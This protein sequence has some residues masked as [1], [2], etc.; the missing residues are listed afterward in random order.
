MFQHFK[1]F[2]LCLILFVV[3]DAIDWLIVF[4]YI[5]IFTEFVIIIMVGEYKIIFLVWWEEKSEQSN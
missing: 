2:I 4:C 1:M 3:G 5:V